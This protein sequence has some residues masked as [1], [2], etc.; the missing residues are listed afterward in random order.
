MYFKWY[1]SFSGHSH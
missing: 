1:S